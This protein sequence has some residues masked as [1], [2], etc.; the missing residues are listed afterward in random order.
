MTSDILR[1]HRPG[2]EIV[3]AIEKLNVPFNGADSVFYDP[4]RETMKRVAHYTASGRRP[5]SWPTATRMSIEP[6]GCSAFR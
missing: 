3:Q 6:P 1:R 5:A 2:I 4:S